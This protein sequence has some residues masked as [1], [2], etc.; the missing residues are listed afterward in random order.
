MTSYLGT[1]AGQVHAEDARV[2]LVAHE[3]QYVLA[4]QLLRLRQSLELYVVLFSRH[5]V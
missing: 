5:C 4:L 3:E 1:A 2:G